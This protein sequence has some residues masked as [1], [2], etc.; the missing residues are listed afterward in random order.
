M[1]ANP[2]FADAPPPLAF[3]AWAIAWVGLVLL[4]GIALFRRREL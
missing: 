1:R 2:F 4:A 3:T